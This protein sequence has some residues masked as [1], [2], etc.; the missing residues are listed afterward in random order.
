MLSWLRPC[1][2]LERIVLESSPKSLV[3]NPVTRLDRAR[4]I[5]EEGTWFQSSVV[6][7]FDVLARVP[8]TKGCAFGSDARVNVA[9]T[10]TPLENGAR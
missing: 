7:Q 2:V 5:T 9:D 3:R 6:G 4:E 8:N 10:R 1:V